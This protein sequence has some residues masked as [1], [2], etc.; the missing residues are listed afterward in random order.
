MTQ[1]IVMI[2][3]IQELHIAVHQEAISPEEIEDKYECRLTVKNIRDIR[4]RL[5]RLH[6]QAMYPQFGLPNFE[7]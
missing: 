3:E 4:D 1:E 2:E 6:M 5:S 7:L